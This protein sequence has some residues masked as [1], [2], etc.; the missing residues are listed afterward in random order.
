VQENII[1]SGL[2]PNPQGLR[3]Y[4]WIHET[5]GAKAGAEGERSDF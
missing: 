1:L 4:I 2:V 3:V 5:E